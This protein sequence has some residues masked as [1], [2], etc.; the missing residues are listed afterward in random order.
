[1][2][3]SQGNFRIQQGIKR[4]LDVSI[5]TIML[6]VLSPILLIIAIAIKLDSPG[7]FIFSHCRVGKNGRPFNVHKFRSM[8][9]GCDEKDHLEHLQRL[10]ENEQHD[11]DKG[12]PYRKRDC[13]PRVTR[14]GTFLR[15]YYLDELPQLWNVIKGE[16]SLVGPRPHVKM[17][18][19]HY[20]LEQMRRLSVRPGLT[21]LWQATGKAECTFSELI[22]L[23]MDYIDNWSLLLDFKII[24]FTVITI[25]K[26][27]E[28]F[29]VRKLKVIPEKSPED[30]VLIAPDIFLTERSKQKKEDFTFFK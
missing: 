7:G 18:V 26:G 15:T 25:L 13:D 1:M 3:T 6:I 22:Q 14:I 30:Q 19:D 29:W 11:K 5:S 10:I 16:M 2:Q 23:D 21:G 24:F 17:E 9:T 27:G 20:T 28:S 12:R 8:I 4:L